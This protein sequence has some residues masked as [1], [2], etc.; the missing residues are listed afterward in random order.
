[1]DIRT[2]YASYCKYQKSIT[3]FISI[4]IYVCFSSLPTITISPGFGPHNHLVEVVTI[5]II[6]PI[7]LIHITQIIITEITIITNLIITDMIKVAGRDLMEVIMETV[8]AQ[9]H[10]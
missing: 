4:C 3:I 6:I 10:F 5:L 1:M 2:A 7:T 9:Y 8:I